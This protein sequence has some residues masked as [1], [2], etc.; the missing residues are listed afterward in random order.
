MNVGLLATFVK[1]ASAAVIQVP[2]D[3]PTIVA[4]IGAANPGDEIVIEA[5]TYDESDWLFVNK[6]L[7]FRATNGV[8]AV[9]SPAGKD[10]VAEVAPG[11]TG[12]VFE[13][14]R[15][16]RPSAHASWTRCVQVQGASAAT[17][18]HCVFTGPANA[19]GLILFF[20]GDATLQSCTFSNFA[21][22]GWA[23]AIA[24]EARDGTSP[25]S[26]VVVRDTLFGSG[27]N[28]WIRGFWWNPPKLGEL[29]VSNCTFKAALGAHG[30]AFYYGGGSSHNTQ[31]DSSKLLRFEDC[32][33]EGTVYEIMEFHYTSLGGPA[34]LQ[35]RRCH[36][37]PYNSTRKMFWLDI[38]APVLFENC[39]FGG[40]KHENIMTVW[41]GPPSVD[42]H[43]CTM[44]NQGIT[45][46]E[47]ASGQNLSSFIWGWDGG[48]TFNVVNCLFYCPTNYSAAFSGDPGSSADR[49]YA[50]VHSVIDHPWV[51]GPKV[52][53]VLGSGGYTN[54]SLAG[55]FVNPAGG[56][57]HLV[58]GTPWVNGGTDL[59]YVW[60]LDRAVRNQGG[61]PDMGAYESAFL[62]VV[63]TVSIAPSGMNVVVSFT[64]VLQAADAVTGPYQDVPG[65]VSPWTVG[66]TNNMKFFR[67]RGF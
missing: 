59:G 49:V 26:D 38:P 8:V 41:G 23:A 57:Y 37:K 11:V 24:L 51:V 19:V 39:L 34:G 20:G 50:V 64:G 12:V 27:C 45:A 31:Y 53:V 48:R 15:F 1:T 36:F 10:A 33:F 5:G 32:T 63:P 29:T 17:F 25:H 2:T 67:A 6:A 52:Q 14:I 42:F 65:A 60:D 47:S 55:A 13:G 18:K 66:V 30:I 58:N 16:E 4:A 9:R 22:E 35:F 46:A 43:H 61:A 3:Q 56:D 54:V 62:P 7:T 40:G 28:S 44:I 21:A